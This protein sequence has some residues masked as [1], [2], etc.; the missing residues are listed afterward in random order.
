[1][2]RASDPEARLKWKEELQANA[3]SQMQAATAMR[4]MLAK[5]YAPPAG[6]A[7]SSPTG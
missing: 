5:Q 1:M 4:E 3:A 2:Q 7:A 6:A